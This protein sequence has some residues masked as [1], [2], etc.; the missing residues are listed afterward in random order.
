MKTLLFVALATL[1]FAQVRA[2]ELLKLGGE[3]KIAVVNAC[4]APTAPLDTAVKK[5][6]NLLMVTAETQKGAWS[7]ADAKKAFETTQANVAVFVIKDS[8]LPMSLIAMEAKWGV[9][10][11]EGLS[12]KGLEKEVL[13][14]STV[15]LGGAA[16]KYPASTMRPV[17][18]PEDLDK[19]AGEVMTFDSLMS[20]FTYLPDLGLKQY[21]MM[22]RE[23][24]IEE[25]LIKE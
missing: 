8:A 10:N 16:S 7:L 9:V 20:I 17:F 11:A 23:D 12:E 4:E 2:E 19:K 5:I 14:V 24:A 1:T 15:L 21:Q 6:G 22:T 3:G 25:G 18:S 13:R